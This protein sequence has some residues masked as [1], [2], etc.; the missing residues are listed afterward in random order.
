M[1]EFGAG[2]CKCSLF[3]CTFLCP[4]A[5]SADRFAEFSQG[6]GGEE[7]EEA[8]QPMQLF[9]V[10]AGTAQLEKVNTWCFRL[11]IITQQEQEVTVYHA[12]GEG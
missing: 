10:R 3:L 9:W 6:E 2:S 7:E 8:W 11:Q 1:R 12:V 5:L 4:F